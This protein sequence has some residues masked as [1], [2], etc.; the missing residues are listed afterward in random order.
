MNRFLFSLESVLQ[1]RVHAEQHRQ[2]EL[3]LAQSRCTQV[4]R[5]LGELE[6]RLAAA[7]A[8]LR[9]CLRNVSVDP[10]EL[11]THVRYKHDLVWEI[12]QLQRDL[13][14]ARLAV[15]EAKAALISATTQR[16][17]LERLRERQHEHWRAE[18]HRRERLAQDDLA[19]REIHR[20]A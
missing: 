9:A 10:A 12:E 16:K 7:S 19:A 14:S 3:A 17:S 2:R 11:A 1:L 6:S 13:N 4:Q 15:D 5:Q 8:E 18:Q 20:S